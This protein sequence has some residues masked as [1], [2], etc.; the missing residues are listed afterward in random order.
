[1][2]KELL[3]SK[4]L[5]NKLKICSF[6]LILFVV[7]IHC[8]IQITDY[9]SP[10]A[11][12]FFCAMQQILSY[13]FA[14]IAVPFFFLISGFLF[15][16]TSRSYNISFFTYKLRRRIRTL[17]IPYFLWVSIPYFVFI[18]FFSDI[19]TSHKISPSFFHNLLTPIINYQL[20]FVRDLICLVLASPILFLFIK[21]LRSFF[22]LLLIVFM[23]WRGNIFF[24]INDSIAFFSLGSF[25]AVISPNIIEKQISLRFIF[26]STLVWCFA[27]VSKLFVDL[28]LQLS[29]LSNIIGIIA[30]WGLLDLFNK[31][32]FYHWAIKLS[33]FTFFIYAC[34]EPLL[35]IIKKVFLRYLAHTEWAYILIYIAAFFTSIILCVLLAYLLKRFMPVPYSILTGNRK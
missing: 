34:H 26:L 4:Q 27:C 5:S 24:I 22:I 16:R 10:K 17:V 21:Y 33:T 28:P 31:T 35:T 29:L 18:S 25:L 20:W 23:L 3:I 12:P 11:M 13:G 8:N 15:F 14:Q 2:S 30:W 7:L 9:G 32:S 6:S 1:M 19:E